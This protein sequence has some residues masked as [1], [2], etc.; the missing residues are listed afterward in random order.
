MA[1]TSPGLWITHMIWQFGD[2]AMK[3]IVYCCQSQVSDVQYHAYSQPGSYTV[4]LF[5]L[6][7][8][9]NSGSAMVTVNFTVSGTTTSSTTAQGSLQSGGLLFGYVYGFNTYDQLIPL[10]SVTVTAT[11]GG[12]HF[13]TSTGTGGNFEMFLPVGAYNVSVS[14]PGYKPYSSTVAI[15]N[16]S[17][18]TV[19]FYLE[20]SGTTLQQTTTTQST[21]A[22]T[23]STNKSQYSPGEIVTVQ[24]KVTDSQNNPVSGARVAIQVNDPG[25]NVVHVQLVSSDQSGGYLDTLSLPMNAPQGQYATYVSASKPGFGNGQAQIQFKVTIGTTTSSTTGSSGTTTTSSS[26][27]R[28]SQSVTLTVTVTTTVTSLTMSTTQSGLSAVTTTYLQISSNSSISNLQFDSQR[29]LINFTASGPSGTIGSTSITFA[30]SL[31]NGL[32]VVLIDNGNTSPTSFVLASNSTH[33]FLSI[34]YPHST[35]SITVGGSNAISEFDDNV[36]VVLLVLLA[37]VSLVGSR[38]RRRH[39]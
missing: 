12:Q 34:T 31:I 17:S 39:G 5:A 22:I 29:K 8:L 33:Y 3:D 32:P 28:S 2:G 37:T 11:G 9:G 24:G 10:E 36:T 18:L 13:A 26:T 4:T 16:G 19:N 30:K 23:V 14:Q 20:E 6:D 25:N 38:S 7:N 1:K 35:H 21:L 15:S 27:T